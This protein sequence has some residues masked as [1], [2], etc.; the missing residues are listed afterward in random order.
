MHFEIFDKIGKTKRAL[1][2]ALF[3]SENNDIMLTFATLKCIEKYLIL[4]KIPSIL[5]VMQ[6]FRADII[7]GWQKS[8]IL[9]S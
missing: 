2:F 3:E 1:V 5:N 6:I 8:I 9:S 7:F 4:L